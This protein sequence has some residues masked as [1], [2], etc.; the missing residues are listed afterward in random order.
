MGCNCKK[1]D[2]LRRARVLLN[3]KQY[4]DLDEITQGQIGGLYSSH[5]KKDGTD[6]QIINWL[7]S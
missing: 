2:V 4:E 7:N 5:F 6:E 3:G 1:K